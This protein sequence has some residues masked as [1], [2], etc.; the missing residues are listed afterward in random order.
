MR[1]LQISGR[2][3][4]GERYI[5]QMLVFDNQS[6]PQKPMPP[7]PFVFEQWKKGRSPKEL[8]DAIGRQ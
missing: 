7:K 5:E 4:T 2:L 1:Q 6:S 3:L 8:L